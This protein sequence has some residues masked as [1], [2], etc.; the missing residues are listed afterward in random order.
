MLRDVIGSRKPT[1]QNAASWECG[2]P[3]PDAPQR[4]EVTASASV[5]ILYLPPFFDFDF[6]FSTL[7]NWQAL[8]VNAG[9]DM[10]KRIDYLRNVVLNRRTQHQGDFVWRQLV[11][12]RQPLRKIRGGLL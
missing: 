6:V 11:I 3:P 1:W 9:H 10:H 2:A 5:T 8:F 7:L 12:G 4:L